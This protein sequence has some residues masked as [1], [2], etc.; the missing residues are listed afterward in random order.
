MIE[1][2]ERV[3]LARRPAV[4]VVFGDVNSALAGALAA[5]KQGV[6]VAHVE[7]G[8]GRSTARCPRR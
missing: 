2:Y 1:G 4:T 3:N 8:S 6:P 5:S 7:S